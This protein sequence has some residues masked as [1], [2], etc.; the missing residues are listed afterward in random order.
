MMFREFFLFELRYRFLRLSTYIYFAVIAL[1][2]I[3]AIIGA[4]GAIAKISVQI[5]DDASGRVLLNSSYNIFILTTFWVYLGF[6]IVASLVGSGILRDDEY[7][8]RAL[9]FTKPIRT[10]D[11]LGGRFLGSFVTLLFIFSATGVGIWLAS[12]LPIYDANVMGANGWLAYLWPYLVSVIPNLYIMAAIFFATAAIFRRPMPVYVCAVAFFIGYLLALNVSKDLDSRILAN[13]LDPMGINAADNTFLKYWTVLEKNSKIIPLA[14]YYLFNRL[15]WIGLASLALMF[16]FFRFR[17]SETKTKTPP[18]ALMASENVSSSPGRFTVPPTSRLDFSGVARFEMLWRNTVKEFLGATQSRSFLVIMLLG[19]LFTLV[20]ARNVDKIMG[21]AVYPLTYIVIESISNFFLVFVLIINTIYAAEMVW[22]ERSLKAAQI[23]DALP[24][25]DGIL[26]LSKLLAM[27][28]IQLVLLLLIMATGLILQSLKGYYHFELGLYG[29]Y[30]FGLRLWDF[31]LLS[32]LVMTIQ[33]LVNH[34]YVGHFVVILYYLSKL[35]M[36]QL[37][38]EHNLYNYNSA[39]PTMIYSD[40]NGFGHF[41]WSTLCFK[42]Y[43]TAL[44]LL[45]AAISALFWV[46]GVETAWSVRMRLARLRFGWKM[47]IFTLLALSLFL[48][49]GAYIFY[50]TNILNTY[51]TTYEKDEISAQYEKL[52]KKYEGTPQL[53]LVGTKLKVDIYPEQRTVRFAG[54]YQLQNKTTE[55]IKLLLLTINSAATIHTLQPQ[56]EN[57]QL[58]FDRE[59]SFVGFELNQAIQPGEQTVLD[60]DLEYQPRGFKNQSVDNRIVANGTFVRSD[61]Y[62]PYIGYTEEEE[63]SDNAKRKRH[64][65]AAKARLAKIDDITAHGNNGLS[66]FADQISLDIVV[67]TSLD[68]VAIAPGVLKKE[69]RENGRRCFH[70]VMERPIW[71]FYCVVSGRYEVLA[72]EWN[73][74]KIEVYYLKKHPFNVR[75]MIDATKKSLEYFSENFSPYQYQE[76]RFVE[77]PRYST[78]AQAHPGMIPWSEA[79]GFITRVD[80]K[81]DD[82]DYPFLFAAHE[83]AHQWWAHQFLGAAVQGGPFLAESLAEYSSLM[84]LRKEASDKEIRTMMRYRLDKYLQGR[85]NEKKEEL[86]L[87]L[88]EQQDYLYYAKGAL[89]FHTLESFVGEKVINTALAKFLQ[90]YAYQGPPYVTTREFARYLKEAV[91]AEYHSLIT[92]LFETITLY[93]NKIGSVKASKLPNGQYSVVVEVQAKK[94]RLES[95]GVETPQPLHD[96]ID[97]EVTGKDDRGLYF[98]RQP[99]TNEHSR[100]EFEVAAPPKQVTID[101]YTKLLNKHPDGNS[102]KF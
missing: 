40:M 53:R 45:M 62:L 101:P 8:S 64:G 4:S 95:N 1:S 39:G 102:K 21:T 70:Y 27:I 92:D 33:V 93:D 42:S 31:V 54:K 16:A 3:I 25:P 59:H 37:G 29:E 14:G 11:Y 100:Y 91:P 56:A 60:F 41:L 58:F 75:K 47:K 67:R 44:A 84:V 69:W 2:A 6:M 20:S 87:F 26:Y 35:F 94:V 78:F 32:V 55:P 77:F 34:K 89:A 24:L 9:F 73:G 72:D 79:I 88:V 43:W 13:F 71:N 80:E 12:L 15:L 81:H 74:V 61:Q 48:G 99:L 66:T 98:Q 63:L 85:S 5:G 7:N 68:Q 49:I 76:V 52:Y 17:P 30:L 36:G 23:Y 65:L 86:P 28:G 18:Q 38:F 22:K 97:I 19:M 50:N 96:W 83:V 51:R 10:V 90:Q 46:R 82:V 57:H